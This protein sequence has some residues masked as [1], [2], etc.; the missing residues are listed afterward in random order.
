MRAGIYFIFLPMAFG[1]QTM[2]QKVLLNEKQRVLVF[3]T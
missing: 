1:L 3:Y 2:C